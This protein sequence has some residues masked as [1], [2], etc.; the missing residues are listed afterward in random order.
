MMGLLNR[1]ARR[2]GLSKPGYGP[3]AGGCPHVLAR[4]VTKHKFTSSLIRPT[5]PCVEKPGHDKPHGDVEATPHRTV[6]GRE[7]T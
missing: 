2:A 1:R 4:W 5:Y 6:G 3:G 7:W